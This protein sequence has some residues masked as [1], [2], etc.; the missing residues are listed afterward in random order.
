M[1]MTYADN[2][3]K[4]VELFETTKDRW[5]N[6]VERRLGFNEIYYVDDVTGVRV[7]GPYYEP[8]ADTLRGASHVFPEL[9]QDVIGRKC[10]D[11]RKD[12]G[13]IGFYKHPC[14]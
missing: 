13:Q 4:V 5:G 1:A 12:G 10:I 3:K 11:N 6:T 2:T 7:R 8:I 9:R 14:V